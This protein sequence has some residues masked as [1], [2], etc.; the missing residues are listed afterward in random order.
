MYWVITIMLMFHGTDAV[1]EREYKLKQF[2]DD[3]SCHKFIHNEK[4]TLLE[5]HIEDYGDALKSFELF[6]ENRYGQ[7]V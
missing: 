2:H 3:W 4:M 5:Q 6:C 7:E 1:V